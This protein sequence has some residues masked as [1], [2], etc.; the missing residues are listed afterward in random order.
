MNVAMLQLDLAQVI[1]AQHVDTA[2]VAV[3]E[4]AAAVY[5]THV[6]HADDIP[7]S[8]YC[9]RCHVQPTY[10]TKETRAAAAKVAIYW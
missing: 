4:L 3:T 1:A 5:N 8:L 2:I 7:V 6:S 10:P 9:V